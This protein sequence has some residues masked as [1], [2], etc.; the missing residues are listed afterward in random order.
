MK[1]R[2]YCKTERKYL[3]QLFVDFQVVF[4]QNKLIMAYYRFNFLRLRLTKQTQNVFSLL[5]N[6]KFFTLWTVLLTNIDP[7][8]ESLYHG[9][10]V[11]LPSPRG[12]GVFQ[13]RA[14]PLIFTLTYN[15]SFFFQFW[16]SFEKKCVICHPE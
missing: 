1:F 4:W 9:V 13:L 5:T 12:R 10:S 8:Y 7:R 3:L 15:Q 11:F 6:E 14:L 2:S 16:V